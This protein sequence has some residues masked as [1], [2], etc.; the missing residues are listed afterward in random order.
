MGKAAVNKISNIIKT[1]QVITITNDVLNSPRTGSA[2][3][4]DP[5]HSFNDI[6]DNYAGNAT[7]TKLE[8]EQIYTSLMDHLTE[9]LVDLNGLLKMDLQH[10]EC[11]FLVGQ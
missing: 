11:L 8:M 10:I 6:V 7:K 1:N 3:K 9:Q 5:Y 2:L 4:A